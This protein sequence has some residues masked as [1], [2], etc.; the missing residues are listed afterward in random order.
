[1]ISFTGSVYTAV[2]LIPK[3]WPNFIKYELVGVLLTEEMLTL[4]L[5]SPIPR[6]IFRKALIQR[7][8]QLLP[9]NNGDISSYSVITPSSY[10]SQG[11][12]SQYG[13]TNTANISYNPNERESEIGFGIGS[14]IL[15]GLGLAA[16]LVAEAVIAAQ[17]GSATINNTALT[18]KSPLNP[19]VKA[20]PEAIMPGKLI[21][22]AL[23]NASEIVESLSSLNSSKSSDLLDIHAQFLLI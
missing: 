12:L 23:V 21:R 18:P 9:P 13:I 6:R 1:M 15:D 4:A 22:G 19:R 20:R 10:A 5:V 3:L 7:Q 17:T 14:S 2:F 16:E 8:K 11:T